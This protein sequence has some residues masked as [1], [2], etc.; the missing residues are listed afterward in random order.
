MDAIMVSVIKILTLVCLDDIV[1]LSQ[2]SR[3]HINHTRFVL[4]LLKE[5]GITLKLKN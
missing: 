4:G 5:A 2:T 3:E 1:I